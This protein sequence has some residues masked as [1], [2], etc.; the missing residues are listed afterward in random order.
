MI[1]VFIVQDDYSLLNIYTILFKSA[2]F[3]ILES[4][5]NGEM[6]VEKYSNFNIKPDVI[7]MDYRMPIKNGIDAMIDILQINKQQKIIFASADI[8]IKERAL[9]L[10]ASVFVVKPFNLH[11]ILNVIQELVNGVKKHI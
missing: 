4:A 7:I 11:I 8:S 6:A 5:I 9:S 10:G 1:K 2:G 3:D